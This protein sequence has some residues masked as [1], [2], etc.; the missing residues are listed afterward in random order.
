MG[1]R[2]TKLGILFEKITYPKSNFESKYFWNKDVMQHRAH[3][4]SEEPA[5]KL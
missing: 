1:V 3:A 5:I 4:G 2:N